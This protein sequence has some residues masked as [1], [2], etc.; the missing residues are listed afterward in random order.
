[1]RN[2]QNR[3]ALAGMIAA[4]LLAAACTKLPMD[5][6]IRCN[7]LRS[8]FLLVRALRPVRRGGLNR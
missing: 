6:K 1:M 3:A 8:S 7:A 4:L 5:W 2:G